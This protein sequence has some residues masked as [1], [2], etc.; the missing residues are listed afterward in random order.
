MERQNKAK[1]AGLWVL[2]SFLL[3]ALVCLVIS[4]ALEWDDPSSPGAMA[5]WTI[6]LVLA[7]TSVG[8][9]LIILVSDIHKIMANSDAMVENIRSLVKGQTQN[10]AILTNVS[11]NILLSDAI[12]SIAFRRNDRSVLEGAIQQDIRTEHWESAQMLI[13]ELE[14]RFGC[15]KEAQDW[16]EEIIR[17][18]SSTRQEKIDEAIK[19]IESLLMIHHYK[20]ALQQEEE[21]LKLYPEND[22]VQKL[23]GQTQ[24]HR[25]TH[26]K[27]LLE[28][29]DRAAN[30]DDFDRGVEIL[31][32]LDNYLTPTEAAALEESARGV[33]RARLHKMGVQ[34]SLFV[35]EKA[36]HKALKLGKEIIREY[37]NSRM[38][39]EVREKMEILEERAK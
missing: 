33:F 19:H 39:Q 18:Q 15:K 3:A 21:L 17:C 9:S 27:E 36:W 16:R 8:L 14:R 24:R 7:M 10:E 37:P 38:A 6:F 20:D 12:K 4:K 5:M 2:D 11:E 30:K 22:S 31:K 28:Q 23:Q 32:L 1:S 13:E 29:L 26:K 35:T 34:F 25:E